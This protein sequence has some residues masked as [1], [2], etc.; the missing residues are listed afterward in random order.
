MINIQY[1]SQN[2][3]ATI[4]ALY[5]LW[6]S[7]IRLRAKRCHRFWVHD[8][9]RR[10]T[11][12]GEFHH[13]LQELRLDDSRFQRYF[14]LTAAQFEDLL[15]RV[16]ARISRL[17]TNYR[18]SIPAAE[19]LSICL[20]YLATGDSYRTIANSFR[21]GVSSVSRI[22]ADVVSATWD[23]LVGEF[24]AVLTTEEWRSI[25]EGFEERW[26]FTL[27]CGAVD[28]KH[29]ATGGR[30]M[31]ASWPTQPLVRHFALAPSICLL[32]I[33]NLE[34]TT[35]RPFPGRTLP[36]DHRLF[37]YHL[38]Q[39]HPDV[40]ERCVKVTCVLHNFLRKTTPTPAMRGSIPGGDVEPLPG[41]GR[42][43]ANNSAR[44]AIR[45]RETLTA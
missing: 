41:L 39:V 10:C 45:V 5:L 6:R 19:C 40:A 18:R 8:T 11:E 14:R 24:M 27:C 17:D 16:G 20:Q 4:A 37:N 33:S 21:V 32:T 29:G 43:A 38:S 42:V 34:L 44:E 3:I 25:A 12:L 7:Q 22:V 36:R 1:N 30:A 31:V 28:G 26:N 35:M 23:C 9:L 15:A 13:L 2:E